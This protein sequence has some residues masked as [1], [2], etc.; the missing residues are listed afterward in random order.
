MIGLVLVGGLSSRMGVDK[1]RLQYH[2]EPQLLYCHNLLK[3]FCRKVLISVRPG[4]ENAVLQFL[5]Q[6]SPQAFDNDAL[7]VDRVENMGPAAALLAAQTSF[8]NE[9]VFLLACDL[10]FV[11]SSHIEKL[12][13]SFK[14]YKQD[15]ALFHPNE[16]LC[17]I[18]SRDFIRD[19]SEPKLQAYGNSL[20]RYMN[21]ERDVESAVIGMDNLSFLENVNTPK[22]PQFPNFRA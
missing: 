12:V 22:Y 9:D 2:P 18:Y 20:R 3:P 4:Q 6:H 10:P 14:E 8:P 21:A 1:Y 15:L 13:G 7:L 19:I 5:A 17:A 11:E 16:P